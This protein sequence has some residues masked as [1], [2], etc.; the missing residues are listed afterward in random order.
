M[1]TDWDHSKS[2][3]YWN[4][5]YTR[6][7]PGLQQPS[8]FAVFCL[9]YLPKAGIILELGCGNGRDAH[10]FAKHGHNV[11]ACDSSTVALNKIHKHHHLQTLAADFSNLGNILD[12]HNIT[13]VYSRFSLHSIDRESAIQTLSWCSN[14]LPTAGKLFIE[15]RSIFDELYGVGT[16]VGIDS[17]VTTH[18]RS[19]FKQDHLEEQLV[20]LGFKIQGS[21]SARGFAPYKQEDPIIIRVIAAK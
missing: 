9:D 20:D 3:H 16:P 21:W 15:V 2:K 4:N 7:E 6:E 17:F 8:A 11:I 19:F 1:L 10:F 13:A 14:N 12:D 18:L 5:F